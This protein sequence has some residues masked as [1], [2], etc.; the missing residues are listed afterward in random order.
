MSAAI[1]QEED[2]PRVARFLVIAM[3]SLALFT[4][5]VVW[6]WVIQARVPE[7]APVRIDPGRIGMLNPEPFDVAH[8]VGNGRADGRGVNG[9]DPAAARRRLESAGWVDRERG[10]VH[11]PIER[12]MELVLD[13]ARP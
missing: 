7:A 13:G 2:R 4:V 11:I 6:A 8:G 10:I 9:I 12:A 3:A 1:R 5:G